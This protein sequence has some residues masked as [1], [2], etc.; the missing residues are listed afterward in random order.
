MDP[1]EERIGLNGAAVV[2][3]VPAETVRGFV[4]EGRLRA[5]RDEEGGLSFS[6]AEVMELAREMEAA[7]EIFEGEVIGDDAPGSSRLPAVPFERYE[8]LLQQGQDYKTRLEERSRHM[9][10]IRKER[11]AARMEI[12][13]LWSEIERLNLIEF[14]RELQERTISTLEEEKAKLESE[15]ERLIQER[16]EL[17]EEKSNL[18][19]DRIRLEAELKALKNRGFWS[20]LFGG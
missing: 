6:L 14:Q 19:E 3:D 11:D 10:E 1:S 13:R 4:D 15:R 17:V 12:D 7:E 18:V 8:R 16:L 9:E 5:E 20:R 2:L